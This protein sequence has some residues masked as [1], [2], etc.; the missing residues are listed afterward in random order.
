MEKSSAQRKSS[1]K[2]PPNLV[3]QHKYPTHFCRGWAGTWW[4]YGCCGGVRNGHFLESEKY[5]FRGRNLQEN[6][7]IS[8]ETATTAK[9]Q[10][11][12]F[13]NS[14]PEKCNSIPQPF[15]TSTRIPSPGGCDAQSL[16]RH[17]KSFAIQSLQVPCRLKSIAAGL[18]RGTLGI[19]PLD[20]TLESASP[21]PTQGSIWHTNTVESGN[22]CRIDAKLM[23][24]LTPEEGRARRIR[25][26]GPGGLCLMSPSQCRASKTGPEI[27]KMPVTSLGG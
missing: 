21:S 9:F 23:S 22:R 11:P 5:I 15:H 14:E 17:K 3:I 24:K 12:K 26:W 7:Q 18:A 16:K 10:A 4:G 8:A 19:G 27:E 20:P 25:G 2:N 1:R 6:P 13:E